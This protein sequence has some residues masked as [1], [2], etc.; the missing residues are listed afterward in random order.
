MEHYITLFDGNFLPQGLVLLESLERHAGEHTL[1]VLCLDERAREVLD[2]LEKPNLRTISLADVETPEL[3]AVKSGR[4][5]AEY[6]WTLTPFTP[7]FVLEREPKA[8]RVTYLDADLF[9]LKSPESIF[10]ELEQSGKSV[11]ITEH[12]YDEEY[13]QS[14]NFG[15]FCVQFIIFVSGAGEVVRKWWEERCLEWCFDRVEDG[16]FGDQKY[17]DDWPERFPAHVHVLG[18]KDAILAPWN[19]RRFSHSRAIA[20]HFHGLRI[21]G[22]RI[23]WYLGFDIP[24]AVRRDIYQPYVKL[25]EQKLRQLGHTVVQGAPESRLIACLRW[26]KFVLLGALGLTFQFRRQ[27][28]S[29]LRVD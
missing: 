22:S 29:P 27:K 15:R 6:C 1:W 12:A 17:L 28:T 19:A 5:W 20:W 26:G 14:D 8:E 23:R 11:L 25:L 7:R 9:F 10:A 13:D 4:T 21:E 16:K 3:L 2:D 18:Q 24:K